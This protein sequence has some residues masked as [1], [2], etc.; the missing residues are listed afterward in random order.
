MKY[1]P[2]MLALCQHNT[3]TY[4]VFFIM[5]EYLMQAYIVAFFPSTVKRS[6]IMHNQL[7]VGLTK[8]LE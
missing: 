3:L 4:Y 6:V 8:L 5:L 2:I 1:L 7:T